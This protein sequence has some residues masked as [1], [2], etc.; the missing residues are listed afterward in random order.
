MVS[1]CV[2]WEGATKPYFVNNKSVKVNSKTYKNTLKR[3][4]A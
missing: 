2:M 4:S 3:A 1:A